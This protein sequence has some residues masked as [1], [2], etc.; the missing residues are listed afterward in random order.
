MVF[1][2]LQKTTLLDYPGKVACTVFTGGCNFRCP[3]CHNA[4]LVLDPSQNEVYTEEDILS[5]IN[6]R[7]GILEGICITGG[8]PLLNKDIFGF[9]AKVRETGICIKVDTNGSFPD[10]IA[11]IISEGLADYIAMDVKNTL[12]KYP[13]TVGIPGFD[14]K[15]IEKSIA[16]LLEGKI[17]YEFRTTTV[18]EFHRPE[19]FIQLCNTIAGAERYFIQAYKDSGDI[20]E[21]GLHP[22][23]DEQYK[24]CLEIAKSIIPSAKLRGID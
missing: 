4:G 3:F 13:E 22:L 24:K 2:G 8:E 1:Y 18:K 5:F 7:K 20:I 14:T 11:R 23:E 15:S 10:A 21:G 19:D 17:G 12:D 16:I 9:L 6:K